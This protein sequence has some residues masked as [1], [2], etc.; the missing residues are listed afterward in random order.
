MSVVVSTSSKESPLCRVWIQNSFF[1][2][3][4]LNGKLLDCL[5]CVYTSSKILHTCKV[6]FI[7]IYVHLKYNN[8][9]SPKSQL[10][11]KY[12][13]EIYII[14]LCTSKTGSKWTLQLHRNLKD[15]RN[16]LTLCAKVNCCF[17]GNTREKYINSPKSKV[18]NEAF[19]CIL[20]PLTSKYLCMQPF[21]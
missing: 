11:T 2:L 14:A 17:K 10:T 6:K 8:Q 5:A 15:I 19:P 12:S 9:Y 18:K 4:D 3:E 1:Q 7:H 20:F 16:F 21:C 13:E